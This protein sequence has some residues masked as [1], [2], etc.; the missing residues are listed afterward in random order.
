MASKHKHSE[1]LV[2]CQ[3]RYTQHVTTNMFVSNNKV[4]HSGR[5]MQYYN[6]KTIRIY[7]RN[8]TINCILQ[9]WG[10]SDFHMHIL[11]MHLRLSLI[12]WNI[13][14]V[15]LY[16]KV[17]CKLFRIITL[18]MSDKDITSIWEIQW[19]SHLHVSMLLFLCCYILPYENSLFILY[20]SYFIQ[21]SSSVLLSA[22]SV[23]LKDYSFFYSHLILHCNYPISH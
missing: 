16:Y 12:F 13:K 22:Y 4:I 17:S 1:I 11:L 7:P 18:Y 23:L 6:M 21:H 5:E 20:S 2:F 3:S 19:G 9:I 14:F 10:Q 15:L 8:A